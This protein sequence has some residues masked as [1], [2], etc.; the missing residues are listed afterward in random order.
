M[1]SLLKSL[2]LLLPPLRRLHEE[3]N[4]YAVDVEKLYLQMSESNLVAEQ[5]LQEREQ[6][7]TEVA[8]LQNKIFELE[9]DN[10]KKVNLNV[11]LS[12]QD[13]LLLAFEKQNNEMRERDG[14]N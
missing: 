6:L 14:Q 13:Q 12:T 2:G 8:I 7:K 4:C 5:L 9:E 11:Q 3:R 1:N 10:R